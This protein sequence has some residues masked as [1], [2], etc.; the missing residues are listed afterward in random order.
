M[1]FPFPS[2]FIEEQL[3]FLKKF[4]NAEFFVGLFLK[5]SGNPRRKIRCSGKISGNGVIERGKRG[6]WPAAP[7]GGF[8]YFSA[9]FVGFNYLGFKYLVI[10]GP[11]GGG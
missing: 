1:S 11:P 5:I 4:L 10:S 8:T 6:V 2:P 9:S 7:P 3:P